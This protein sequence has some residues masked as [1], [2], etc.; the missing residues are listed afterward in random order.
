MNV[1]TKPRKNRAQVLVNEAVT[2]A[3][4]PTPA[5]L[6]ASKPAPTIEVT[7]LAVGRLKKRRPEFIASAA[8]LPED[9]AMIVDGD[10][11]DPEIGHGA[12]LHINKSAPYKVGDFV[13]IWF[14]PECC[15]PGGL[16]CLVKRMAMSIFP[17]LKFPYVMSPG[18]NV[19]PIFVAE[20]LKPPQTF[21][22]PA[23][24]IIAV[25]KVM[26]LAK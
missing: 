10:C 8:V 12:K 11:L 26:G 15:K 23:D 16:Q 2:R 1:H 7:A 18:S 9:Y 22:Y 20:M 3:L 4:A 21:Y 24:K 17:G 25:H 5:N 13:A 6:L 14:R 19:V